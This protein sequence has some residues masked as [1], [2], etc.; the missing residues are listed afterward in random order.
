MK[1]Y[2]IQKPNNMKLN[3]ISYAMQL[4]ACVAFFCASFIINL[5]AKA[6]ENPLLLQYKTEL[7]AIE[8]YL[9]N[10]KNLSAKFIQK[11]GNN[12]VEGRFYLSRPGKMRVEYT[13]Q[14]K[15]LI[16]VNGSVL[17][18]QDL[19]LEETSNLSTNTTP[20]SFLTRPT[21]SFWAK[22]VEVTKVI[23]TADSIAVSVIKKNRTEAGEFSLIFK[24]NPELG[25][26]K[27]EVKNDLDQKTSVTLRDVAFD[28]NIDNNLF[29]IRNKN[30]PK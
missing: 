2:I 17:T 15:I 13:N 30:L 19:E 22:D 6:E 27:M 23:K 16:I 25:F 12:I 1:K 24:T 8:N 18:Y 9:N 26:Y 7:E 3:K 11:T 5:S 21:I 14:P 10:I 28:E 29:I 20:A 4:V